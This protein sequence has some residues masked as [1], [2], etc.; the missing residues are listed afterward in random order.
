MTQRRETEPHIVAR[1]TRWLLDA[2]PTIAGGLIL[3]VA[4]VVL[5]VGWIF[6]VPAAQR[7]A[8]G[9][10]SMKANT[11][12][13]FILLSGA[14][15]TLV[16][17]KGNA[18]R[19]VTRL[20]ALAAVVLGAATLSQDLW[21]INLGID[22]LIAED[23]H[24]VL[25]WHP[26]RMSPGTAIGFMLTG[27][28]LTA[29]ASPWRRARRLADGLTFWVGVIGLLAIIGYVYNLERLYEVAPFNSM[30]VHTAVSFCVLACGLVSFDWREGPAEVLARDSVEGALS[31][32][33]V[34][35]GLLVPAVLGVVFLLGENTG[36]YGPHFSLALL[37]LSTGIIFVV[38]VWRTGVVIE[39]I[40]ERRRVSEHRFRELAD[41]MPQIV[42]SAGSDGQPDYVNQRWR[43]VM[44]PHNG[45][46]LAQW[47]QML[48][49]CDRDEWSERWQA[50][51]ASGEPFEMEY[52]VR[53]AP[54]TWQWHLGRAVRVEPRDDEPRWYA[55]STDIDHQKRVQEHL[56]EAS[57]QKDDFMA[58]L[59]HELRNPIASIMSSVEFLLAHES[60]A[61][62][63]RFLEIIERQTGHMAGLIEDLVD[64]ASIS[65]GEYPLRPVQL[66]VA[67]L[68]EQVVE[69]VAAQADDHD[70]ELVVEVD[71]PTPLVADPLRLQQVVRNLVDNA[72]KYSPDGSRIEVSVENA[73][74]D[75]EVVLRVAD[76]GQGIEPQALPFIFDLF[77]QTERSLDRPGGGLGVG[78]ALVKRLAEMHGGCVEAHSEGVGEG[79]EFVIRL[80][81]GRLTPQ[82]QVAAHSAEAT[83]SRPAPG[84]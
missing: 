9:L 30:A 47:R 71:R 18:G 19:W 57:R 50:S 62:Q 2:A 44:K 63:Q 75:G 60:A 10:A 67:D 4:I 58:I 6:G 70:H 68:V 53:V 29:Y 81:K 1:K 55:T 45:D 66:D 64:L 37:A 38:L 46:A 65:R 74:E 12:V 72:I 13:G 80:P 40:D 28:A 69:D 16:H 84:R 52:R 39:S 35:T 14:L 27:V 8:P 21:G 43:E 77:M 42:W 78:L 26:G 73:D 17:W 51:I 33:L 82:E 11:A 22:T 3:A 32:R 59:G 54:D 79:A 76:N 49:P 36:L 15:L 20:A 48:H 23:P 5:V 25:T 41:A 31:R 56:D 7:I 83:P 24:S 34:P 61:S